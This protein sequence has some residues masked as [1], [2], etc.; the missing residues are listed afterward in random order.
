MTKYREIK[1]PKYPTVEDGDQYELGYGG[2]WLNYTSVSIGCKY[3]YEDFS[4]GRIRRPIKEDNQRKALFIE[5]A[6]DQ[7]LGDLFDFLE[8]N[9]AD[10]S[11]LDD[12]L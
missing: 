11:F 2:D 7:Y 10:L 6:K 8:D 12:A 5:L 3:S 9:K 1:P 4:A